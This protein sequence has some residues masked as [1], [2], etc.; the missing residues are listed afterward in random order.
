MIN[1]GSVPFLNARPLIY[2][3]ENGLVDHDFNIFYYDPSLLSRKLNEKIVDIGL[4][5]AAEFL[6]HDDYA[7]LPDI[8]ISSY[9][10][11][12][13]VVLLSRDELKSIKTIAIDSRSQS[14]TALIKIIFELFL[15]IN[16]T[17]IKRKV[18]ENFFDGVDS[19]ML[20]GNSGL[21]AVH[22]KDKNFLISDIGELWTNFTGLPFVYALFALKKDFDLKRGYQAL[23]DSKNKGYDLIPKIVDIEHEKLGL[24][25]EDCFTYLSERIKFDLDSEKLKGLKEYQKLLFELKELKIINDIEFYNK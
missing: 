11:V 1:L 12:D 2:P 18:G 19:G 25:K 13:S 6:K 7:A 22:S 16:P 10:K 4:I 24:T 15:G 20:I 3:L 5:P 14:S 23:I 21:K 8:S 9:G 17:Y